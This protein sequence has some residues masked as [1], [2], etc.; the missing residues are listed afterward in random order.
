M[1]A[2]ACVLYGYGINCDRE[3]EYALSASGAN[4]KRTHINELI[5]N[6]NMFEDFNLIAFPGG[7]SYGDDIGSGKVLANKIKFNLKQKMSEFVSAGKLVIGICNGFQVLVKLGLLPYN[8][9]EQKVTLIS[10]DSNKFE[11]RWVYLRINQESKCVFTKGMEGIMLPIRHGEGK[12]FAPNNVL[13]DLSLKN[14]IVM[15][16]VN[17]KNEFRGY[18][19]NPNGSVRN[20]AGI[21]NEQ[22]NVFGLMPHPEAYCSLLNNPYWPR[23]KQRITEWKGKGMEIFENAVKHI[24]ETF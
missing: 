6:P 21:C 13:E 15:Q 11:D 8:D 24:I 22:G 9:F 14:Q 10:N 19:Y 12:F 18:P 1:K 4:V 16:Y 23:A 5:M 3:T 17:E 2:N 20:I 7:F